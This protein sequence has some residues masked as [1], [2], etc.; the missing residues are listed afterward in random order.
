[1]KIGD[2]AQMADQDEI[3]LARDSMG[4]YKL[5]SD[6]LVEADDLSPEG[7]FPEY[8]DFLEAVT[9]TGGANP[10]WNTP[11]FVECPGNLA[12]QLVDMGL[13]E[14]GAAFR[15]NSVRK[16]ASGSWEYSVSEESPDL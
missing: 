10:S 5:E 15:I 6:Q 3:R 1:M 8:G 2:K 7:E 16:N 13:V 11:V 4:L 14:E 9:T 12:K